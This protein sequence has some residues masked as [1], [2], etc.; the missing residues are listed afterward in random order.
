METRQYAI[1]MVV[2]GFVFIVGKLEKI[3]EANG[4]LSDKCYIIRLFYAVMSFLLRKC[5]V[6]DEVVFFF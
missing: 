2:Y 5:L 4:H 1:L 6:K 3:L